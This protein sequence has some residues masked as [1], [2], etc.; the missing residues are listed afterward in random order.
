M[1]DLRVALGPLSGR[2]AQYVTDGCLRRYLRARSWNVKKAEKMLRESLA[3]RESYK[4]ED[5]RWVS[6]D[7]AI[8]MILLTPSLP[9]TFRRS[10][11]VNQRCLDDFISV[12][13]NDMV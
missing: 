2:G 10:V 9:F 12:E 5:I 3:W 6:S 11:I 4:P 8:V 7:I 1:N 13:V